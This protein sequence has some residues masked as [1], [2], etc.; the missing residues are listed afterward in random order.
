MH[1]GFPCFLTTGH[2]AAHYQAIGD[3]FEHAF[4][5]LEEGGIVAAASSTAP[6]PQS[7]ADTVTAVPL[8][9]PQ[10]EIFLAAQMGDAA[11][12]AFNELLTVRFEGPFGASAMADA[13]KAAVQRHDALRGRIG[14]EGDTLEVLSDLSIDVP[15][16]DFSG[17]DAEARLAALMAED[18]RSPFDL[19]GGPLVRASIVK[20]A[21]ENHAL[22]FTA[23]HIVCDGW[24]MNLVLQDL[25][26]LY[27]AARAGRDAKLPP[28]VGFRSYAQGRRGEPAA[29]MVAFWKGLFAELPEPVELPLDRPRPAVKTF[30][31][32]SRRES[33]GEALCEE[34]RALARRE[35]VSLFTVLFA[36]VQALF[37]RLSRNE[38]VVLTV[39]MAGQ[40][41]LDDPDLVG[42]CVNFLPVPVQLPFSKSFID[43]VEAVEARLNAVLDHQDYTLGS[44]VRDLAVPRSPDR[45]PLSDIQFNLERVG[46]RL[47]FEG[48]ASEVR[49]NPKAFV[50]FD[51]FINLIEG[52]RDIAVEVDYATGLFDEATISRWI[53]HLRAVLTAVAQASAVTIAELPLIDRAASHE[54][55]DA[56]TGVARRHEYM[57]PELFERWCDATPDA[58]AVEFAG[59][60]LSYR[61]IEARSNRLAACLAELAP[62][63]ALGS[64]WR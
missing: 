42:H 3:A 49:T 22:L 54:L 19:F 56:A 6:I 17:P 60:T 32:A 2:T 31:G 12:M 23:H 21:P 57:L 44:L 27:N 5:A 10:M 16:L 13:V 64:R 45:T 59:E 7:A 63:P 51:L 39:P 33:L 4:D 20:L 58:V 62:A 9:E 15:L 35:G 26:A 48:L 30:A 61:E 55:I 11:S 38:N 47:V 41:L 1:E 36:A 18:A 37:A 25:A 14:K 43:H 29:D 28:A 50:N 46:S 40:A 24:S 34:V 8:T 52:D 53:G